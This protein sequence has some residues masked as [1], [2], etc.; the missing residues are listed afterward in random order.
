MLGKREVLQRLRN[1]DEQLQVVLDPSDELPELVIIGGSALLLKD[2]TNMPR[3]TKDIDVLIADARIAHLLSRYDIND[4]ANTFL[5][6]FPAGWE[7]RKEQL[8]LNLASLKVHTLSDED[9][10]IAKVLAGREMDL[11]DA[12]SMVRKGSVDLGKVEEILQDPSEV[13]LNLENDAWEA[14]K[15]NLESV[16]GDRRIDAAPRFQ[17]MDEKVSHRARRAGKVQPEKGCSAGAR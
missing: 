6:Q 16:L 11:R 7:H 14:L 8:S 17:Q 2:S 15:R 4:D 3:P 12:E 1:L 13:F 9:L 5:Y 10:C